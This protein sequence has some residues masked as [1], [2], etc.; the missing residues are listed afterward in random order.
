VNLEIAKEMWDKLI[1]SYEGNEKVNDAKLQTYR[2][3]IEQLKM[4]EDEMFKKY[5]LIV[6]ELVNA[7]KSL[8]EKI[9]EHS[10]VQKILRYLADRFK[11]KVFA[12]EEINDLKSLA[13][14]QILGTLIAYEM[15]I[16]KDKPTSRKASFKADKN[17]DSEPDEIE[18]T[19]VRRI[20]KGSGKYQ[21]KI[22]FK[23]FNC[24]RIGHFAYKCPH[25]KKDQN[26]KGEEKY[27]SKRFGKK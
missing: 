26:S 22:P 6:E 24:G 9:E 16:V 8:G 18:E 7:M 14:D 1:G 20:K 3:Q 19:I 15:M 5:F 21:G 17:E 23:F 27:K 25:K 11:P 12:I 10:L 2:V 13:F 4:K